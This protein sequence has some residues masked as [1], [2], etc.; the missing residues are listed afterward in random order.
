MLTALLQWCQGEA[1]RAVRR[2]KLEA[3]A[4]QQRETGEAMATAVS[5]KVNDGV[6]LAADSATTRR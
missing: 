4:Q 3:P 1:Q 5:H 2:V 6:V